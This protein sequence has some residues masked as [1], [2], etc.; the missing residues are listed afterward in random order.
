MTDT[1]PPHEVA[2]VKPV[3]NVSKIWLLP[4]A[5]LLVGLW[6]VYYQWANQGPL[7]LIEFNTATGLEAGKTK[8]KTRDVDIGVV[9]KIELSS[10]VE[11]VLV[12]A[13][14]NS[15]IEPLLRADNQFWIVSPRVSLSGVS[16]LGTIL[17]GPYINMEPGTDDESSFEFVALAVPPVT[18]T[19]TLMVCMLPLTAIVNLPIKKVIPSCI[20]AFRWV[21]LKISILISKIEAFTTTPLSKPLT[22]NSSRPILSFGILVVFK[23]ISMPTASKSVPAV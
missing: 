21:N 3:R 10:E 6:M 17:S 12:T 20:K 13:R 15:N 7:I 18:K 2:I 5:A 16:G 8:I 9:K 14:L 19:G 4:A 1:H 11:G 23:W 22:M